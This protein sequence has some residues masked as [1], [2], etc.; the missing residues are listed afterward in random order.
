MHHTAS[1]QWDK[2]SGYNNVNRFTFRYSM[3]YNHV[4]VHVQCQWRC[5]CLPWFYKKYNLCKI[6][7]GYWCF[8]LWCEV[9]KSSVCG[10][11]RRI[12]IWPITHGVTFNLQL[13]HWGQYLRVIFHNNLCLCLSDCEKRNSSGKRIFWWSSD[14][15]C[16]SDNLSYLIDFKLC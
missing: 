9:K 11:S 12:I 15:N 7:V 16:C 14:D 5:P 8:S 10:H 13:Q 6:K 3:W 4:R 1:R 2:N